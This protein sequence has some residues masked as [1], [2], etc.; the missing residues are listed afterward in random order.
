[1]EI[2]SK[3]IVLVSPKEL[4]F[5]PKNMNV[6]SKEQISRLIK[7][8]EY[9]GFRVPV[10]VQKGTNLVVSGNGRLEAALQMKLE[11][12]PV[13]YQEFES[14]AQLYAFI[15]SDN[16]IASWAELDLDMIKNELTNLD[17]LDI[18][19]LG[20]EDFTIDLSKTEEGK[21]SE[22]TAKVEI[23]V[24]EPTGEK[25][26]INE[27]CEMEKTNS[28]IKEINESDLEEDLKK[29]L[30]LSSY[31]H[32]KFNYTKIAE[33]YCHQKDEVKRIFENHALVLIDFDKAIE[34][35][36]VEMSKQLSEIYERE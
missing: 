29:F 6:H 14:E 26:P 27:L 25:P 13:I 7:L 1:M 16:A 3:E 2:K 12:I 4:A 10:I 11:K 33:F 9:Q 34:N 30:I 18:D 28:L 36:F 19:L 35:G 21:D 20:I 22:Y 17:E 8:I 15:V 23:P 31:R 24:Y 32:L 5:H